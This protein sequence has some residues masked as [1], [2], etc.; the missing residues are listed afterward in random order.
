[1]SMSKEL[2]LISFA[3]SLG[4]TVATGVNVTY[5]NTLSTEAIA[6]QQVAQV[7]EIERFWYVYN[8][9]RGLRH[10]YENTE[11]G[12]NICVIVSGD[13]ICVPEK[14]DFLE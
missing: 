14:T 1:M 5:F 10:F 9:I 13:K 8:N 6:Q 2:L 3:G 12:R 11:N 7:S 4:F